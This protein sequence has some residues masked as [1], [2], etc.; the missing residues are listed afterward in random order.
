[1]SNALKCDRCGKYFS[2]FLIG[3]EDSLTTIPEIKVQTRKE[4]KEH[5]VIF[6][7]KDVNFCPD[8]TQEFIY[9]FMKG[10]ENETDYLYG[11]GYFNDA[12]DPNKRGGSRRYKHEGSS[13]NSNCEAS[14]WTDDAQ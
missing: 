7:K 12:G 8:C 10:F 2:P 6:N 3:D 13:R 1:M 14:E 4:Y 5:A 9:D 11:Y